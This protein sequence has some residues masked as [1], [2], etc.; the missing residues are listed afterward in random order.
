[1]ISVHR[2]STAVLSNSGQTLPF[3]ISE[4]SSKRA[5]P[6]PAATPSAEGVLPWG[7][8]AGAHSAPSTPLCVLQCPTTSQA[9][10]LAQPTATRQAVPGAQEHEQ[11]LLCGKRGGLS[12]TSV[13][14]MV[15]VVEPDS[16]PSC[17]AMSVA[18]ITTSYRSCVSRSRSATAVRITPGN[19]QCSECRHVAEHLQSHRTGEDGRGCWGVPRASWSSKW[20]QLGLPASARTAGTPTLN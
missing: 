1:M 7:R 3:L 18:R 12:L 6:P 2:H 11:D 16:P 8:W 14:T 13:T 20:D 17:P 15:T 10:G 5:E 9:A 4:K 19:G